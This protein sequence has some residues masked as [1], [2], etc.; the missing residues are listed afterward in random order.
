MPSLNWTAEGG[1]ENATVSVGNSGGASGDAWDTVTIGANATNVYD[2]SDPAVGKRSNRIATGASSVMS[3]GQWTA[4]VAA[5]WPAGLTT[6]YG[7]CYIKIAAIPGADRTFV[8]FSDAAGTTNRGNIRVRSTGAIRLRNAANGTVVTS[9]TILSLNTWYRIEYRVDGSVAGDW[10]IVIFLGNSTSA[11]ETLSGSGANF[12]GAIGTVRFGYV[13]NVANADNWWL[14]GMNVND[15]GLP[16]PLTYNAIFPGRPTGPRCGDGNLPALR[17]ADDF[18]D[19]SVNGAL[20]T[21][22]NFGNATGSETGGQFQVDITSGGTGVAQLLSQ[23]RYD[24]T[25]GFFAAELTDAGVQEA[26]LQAYAVMAQLDSNNQV[27][28]TVA[29]GFIGSIQNVAGSVT[30]LDFTAYDSALH[31]WF[32]VR[33][34]DGDTFWEVSANGVFWTTLFT[35]ANPIALDDVTLIIAADTFLALGTNKTVTFGQ[36]AA[37]VLT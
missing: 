17:L 16:G 15:V 36:V 6:N 4:K 12:G 11:L 8:E 27:Y 13:A 21:Q 1:T 20:W 32:R 2:P 23:S 24:L 22:F 29:N 5:R 31:R 28:I 25:G 19:N 3:Y 34:A 37:P 18:A 9:A 7:R 14:D 26:G 30:G 33:E 35:T 10:Q